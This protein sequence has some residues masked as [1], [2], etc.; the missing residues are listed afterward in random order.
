MEHNKLSKL[1]V[2]QFKSNL[3][4]LQDLIKKRPLV[5]L[6]RINEQNIIKNNIQE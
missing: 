6:I 5:R 2:K 3:H 4:E 1:K